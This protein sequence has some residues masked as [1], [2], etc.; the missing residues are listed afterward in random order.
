[1]GI[2]ALT[3]LRPAVFLDRDGVINEDVFYPET[4]EWEAPLDP[5]H[6][7]LRPRVLP[8]LARL[9]EAGFA[10]VLV[11]NQAAHAKGKVAL[12]RLV[13]VDRRLRF[14]L[15]EAGVGFTEFYYSYSHP[16]GVVP[17]FSGASLERKPSPYFLLVAAA[18]HDL[19][20]ARSWMVGDR[21]TDVE[22]GAAAGVRTI[23]VDN[24][25][26]GDKAGG[27]VPDC[28]VADLPAAVDIILGAFRP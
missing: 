4:G 21:G 17:G 25:H 20:L 8:A 7:L 27:A 28:R 23:Q 1:M 12:E 26:A 16:Q 9:A 22:C 14:L 3:E 2:G 5:D 18:R 24:P 19:D 15:A 13:A 6:L 11:S 10:L